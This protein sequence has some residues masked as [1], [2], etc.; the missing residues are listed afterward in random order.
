MNKHLTR[1]KTGLFLAV[2]A[3]VSV[4][5]FP[6]VVFATMCLLIVTAAFWEWLTLI[7]IK[8]WAYRMV[9]LVVFWALLWMLPNYLMLM[10]H[11]SLVWWC[12]ALLLLFF[13]KRHLTFLHNKILALLIAFV[14]LVPTWVSVVTLHEHNRLVLFYLIML[15]SF[16]DTGA[17]FVGS[18]YGRHPL[19]PSVSPKK[20]FEGLL[21]GLVIGT[22]AGLLEV[23]FM[24]NLSWQQILFWTLLSVVLI[25]LSVL[26]DLF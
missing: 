14:V 11:V 26:G 24:P 10:L 18:R 16:A 20:S 12:V 19:L 25:L 8:Q 2:L 15:V 1:I 7:H 21:G 22:L 5:Y 13:P 17:Y 3:I 9:L 6:D 4:F 23:L